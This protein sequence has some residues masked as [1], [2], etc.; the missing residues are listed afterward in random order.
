MRRRTSVLMMAS[1]MTA[2]CAGAAFALAP[3]P[4]TMDENGNG[5]QLGFPNHG[6]MSLDEG[7]GALG[8]MAL[9]YNLGSFVPGDVIVI[10]PQTGEVSDVLRFM[11]GGNMIFYSDLPVPPEVPDLADIGLPTAYQANQLIVTEVGQ[12]GYNWIDYA[13][14]PGQ[15]GDFSSVGYLA[16]YHIIS[17]VP[18]PATLSLLALGGLAVLRRRR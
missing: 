11:P 7:P 14:Q 10:E 1:F 8:K 3:L 6:F 4:M 18:E 12:E 16:T 15:P 2:A 5:T 13:P 9:K 17:D